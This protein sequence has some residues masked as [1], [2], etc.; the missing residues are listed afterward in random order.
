MNCRSIRNKT[1]QLKTLLEENDTDVAL[2]QETWL[3]KGDNSIYAE[4]REKGFKIFKLERAEKRGGGLAILLNRKTCSKMSVSYNYKYDCFDNIV[5]YAT[6][7]NIKLN[8]INIYR[9]PSKS[10]SDF[11]TYFDEFLSRT[12]ERDGHLIISGDF[13][14]DL[15]K[16]D[17]ISTNFLSL[18]QKYDLVQLVTEAT[19]DSSLLDYIIV[20]SSSNSKISLMPNELSLFD[21][22]HK[23]LIMKFQICNP[24]DKAKSLVK[25]K[26]RNYKKLDYENFKQKLKDSELVKATQ[27]S[28]ANLE[29]Y[30]A[31]YN[32][33]IFQIIDELCPKKTILVSLDKSKKWYNN[34]LRDMKRKKRRMERKFIKSPNTINKTNFKQ[35]KHD[36]NKM[37]KQA[38]IDFY[39]K[40]LEK[41]K[42]D[43][44]NLNNT[45]AELTGSKPPKVYPT[46]AP[47]EIIAEEMAS[48]YIEKID[49]IRKK[50]ISENH[51][52]S[53]NHSNIQINTLP[54]TTSFENFEEI[55]YKTLSQIIKD[56]KKKFC[57]LDPCP[58][59]ALMEV[60]EPLYPVILKIINC[61]IISSKFPDALKIGIIT[62]IIKDLLLDPEIYKHFRP[63][64]SLPFLSKILEKVLYLQLNSYLKT[65][66]LYPSYQ[67]A[68]RKYHSCETTL[69][70]MTDEIQLE[71]SK[72]KIHVW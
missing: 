62:P 24:I 50:I 64:C 56:L 32:D 38:R 16:S 60:S 67:S 53:R 68:Y 8:I 52:I 39:S 2:L 7:G 58:I 28:T 31:T 59:T 41:Y 63:V 48:F 9:P 25:L 35:I 29:E 49:N 37:V 61:C 19:R 3:H 47:E 1:T 65:N 43:P 30:V 36:Y 44:K 66:K 13:N 69:L 22:D 15:M 4:F 40:K 27:V 20:N 57:T 71:I 55:D 14:V 34:E 33:T 70:K 17:S 5:C 42:C 11:I 46:H 45:L 6:Y 54:E 10:K 72:K 23:P 26:N 21:S 18:L 51:H 12:L